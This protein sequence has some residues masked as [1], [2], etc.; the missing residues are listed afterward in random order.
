MVLFNNSDAKALKMPLNVQC[1]CAQRHFQPFMLPLTC[2]Y[3]CRGSYPSPLHAHTVALASLQL[4]DAT[5]P[6][7]P[8]VRDRILARVSLL[9]CALAAW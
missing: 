3:H 5:P 4:K 6:P 8:H 1:L 9:S 2:R 7:H